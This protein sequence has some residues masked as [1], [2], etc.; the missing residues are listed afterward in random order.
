MLNVHASGGIDMMRA[1]ADAAHDEASKAGLPAPYVLAVT[2]LTSLSESTLREVGISTLMNEQVVALAK[3]AQ[4]SGL[5]GVVASPKESSL[6]RKAD[7]SPILAAQ[8][9]KRACDKIL[10]EIRNASAL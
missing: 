2:V 4:S 6:I 5:D 1:A 10:A 8:D 3:L 7:G 9:R